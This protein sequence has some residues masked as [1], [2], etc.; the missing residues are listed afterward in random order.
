MKLTYLV[1]KMFYIEAKSKFNF[2]SIKFVQLQVEQ[3]A[4][5]FVK[6]L[7]LSI[8]KLELWSLHSK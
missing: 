8:E 5:K 6:I 1:G 4:E 2:Q 3:K 7:Q